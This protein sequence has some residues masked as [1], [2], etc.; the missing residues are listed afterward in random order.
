MEGSLIILHR[1]GA[2]RRWQMRPSCRR[3]MLV[4]VVRRPLGIAVV[5]NPVEAMEVEQV[6]F[7]KHLKSQRG[8]MLE[9][10]QAE[11]EVPPK[12]EAVIV[13]GRLCN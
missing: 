6:S 12:A 5:F 3:T 9:S 7:Y 8:S 11:A 2:W 13:C 10:L 1:L 4:E